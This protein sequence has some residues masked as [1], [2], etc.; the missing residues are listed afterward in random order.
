MEINTTL[1]ASC[2]GKDFAFLHI[3]Y[4]GYA[5]PPIYDRTPILIAF[6]PK[7]NSVVVFW[8]YILYFVF[9]C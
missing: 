7:N 9:C 2:F 1:W 3:V 4:C 6:L 8:K 5:M